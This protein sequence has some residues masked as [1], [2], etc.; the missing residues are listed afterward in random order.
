MNWEKACQACAQIIWFK[1]YPPTK[2]Y[3]L[4]GAIVVF[5]EF[6]GDCA[7]QAVVVAGER[8]ELLADR[9]PKGGRIAGPL[10]ALPGRRLR[11]V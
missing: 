11:V 2:Q 9:P 1:N 8:M 6:T 10:T 5:E 4:S 7:T 3:R